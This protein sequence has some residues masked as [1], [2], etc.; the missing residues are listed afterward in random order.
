M[1][2]GPISYL[3]PHELPL[4]YRSAGAAAIRIRRTHS[5]L[6]GF[7]YLALV[8]AGAASTA[9]LTFAQYS[10]PLQL[11]SAALFG[12][13][14]V[15]ILIIELAGL[16]RKSFGTRA[17]A[18]SIRSI[19]W[20][21]MAKAAPFQV[22]LSA[23]EAENRFLASLRVILNARES[24]K[25]LPRLEPSSAEITEQMRY[26]RALPAGARAATYFSARINRQKTVYSALA[27]DSR[28]QTRIAAFLTLFS[29]A[30]GA[31]TAGLTALQPEIDLPVLP[32]LGMIATASLGWGSYRRAQELTSSHRLTAYELGLIAARQQFVNNDQDL[33]MLATDAEN[34]IA[35]EYTLW[36]ARRI[37]I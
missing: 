6:L 20:R 16:G 23:H 5:S 2:N 10:T 12:S 34:A 8:L 19:S 15:A 37:S 32:A 1:P 24:L 4:L 33:S 29:L 11:G 13:A 22:G 35:K 26:V 7:S 3:K 9:A 31:V 18:E 17:L 21:Y 25:V 27:A 28:G 30:A 14:L 36:A